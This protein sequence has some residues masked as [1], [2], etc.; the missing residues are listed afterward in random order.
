MLLAGRRDYW[1]VQRQGGVMVCG[2]RGQRMHR[3]A[4]LILPLIGLIL[5]VILLRTFS[6]KPVDYPRVTSAPLPPSDVAAALS[7][8][9]RFKTISGTAF[10]GDEFSRFHGW[11]ERRYEAFHRVAHRQIIAGHSLLF[12]WP[13][14]Q[15][16]P[17]GVLFLA[18]QD[19]VPVEKG[20]ERD[21]LFPP[22]SGQ[23]APCGDRP[24]DCVWGRGAMD[25]KAA[26]IGIL[27]AA[28]R[29]AESGWQPEKTLLFAL[30]HDEE[31]GGDGAVALAAAI[32]RGGWRPDWLIDEG[33]LVTEGITPGI[34]RPVAFIGV[35]EK[36][37][38]SVEL[39]AKAA[40]G[41]S[42]MPPQSTA[43]GQLARAVVR[44]E[45]S[46]FPASLQGLTGAMF[47]SV[48]PYMSFGSRVAFAN[49]WLFGG[50][51]LRRLTAKLSTNAT[52]R[53]TQAATVFEGSEQD[54]ILPQ[55]ARAVINFRIHPRDSISSVLARVRSVV[56]DPLVEV[57]PVD[58]GLK[59]EPSRISELDGPGY[60]GLKRAI[61]AVFPRA[62]VAPGLFIAATDSRHYAHLVHNIYRFHPIRIGPNDGARIHGTNERVTVKNLR[63]AVSF[64][65]TLLESTN[66]EPL[67]QI[68]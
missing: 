55:R 26:L 15:P 33:L 45:E 28:N 16:G 50:M 59:S 46:P 2:D 47:D 66:G 57:R 9:I 6:F 8:S 23:I 49:Q 14:R 51:I 48:G 3:A 63:E 10:D 27:E 1:P 67:S 62:V 21:W 11:L 12:V 20:T 58:A 60:V 38:L 32:K 43:V 42:S 7:E 25:M 40:G 30:G 22:F 17:G 41:H 56:N 13:G 5:A 65:Q 37:F 68:K 36:G 19:V 18:H 24:G 31:T 34:E 29:L 39:L 52:V 54:N 64:Y 4:R 53:T 35:A 44:L 61:H